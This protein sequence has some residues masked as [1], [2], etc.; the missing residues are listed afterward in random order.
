MLS[1]QPTFTAY[2]S[3][4]KMESVGVISG[5]S[6][7][8]IFKKSYRDDPVA[9]IHD[10]IKWREGE[11][12]T[13]Y[14]DEIMS[15][16]VSE[17]RVSVRA[18][19]G[20]GKTAVVAWAV[21]WFALTNDGDI[22][23]KIP[24]T[25]SAW[26]QLSHFAMPEVH[27]WS[28]ALVWD[29]IGRAPYDTRIELT[30]LTLSLKTGEMFALASDNPA[31]LEGAHASRLLYIFDE[32][33]EIPVG[34][35]DSAEGAFSA[36]DCKWLSV[37][38]PGEP[39]GRFYDIQSRTPGTEDWFVRHITLEEAIGSGRISQKWANDRLLQWGE[40]SAVYQNRVLGEFASSEESGVIPLSWVEKAV[41]RW[42][43][44]RDAGSVLPEFTCVGADIARSGEDR[45]VLAL[46]FENI[47]TELRK[48]SREDTMETTGRI[49]GIL[50]KY[51]GY[52]AVDV[53]GIGAGVVDRLRELKYNV[54][55]FNASEHTDMLDATGELMFANVRSAAWWNMRELLDPVNGHEIA[56][57]P[58]DLL[59]G[60]LTSVHW[61]VQSGGKIIIEPKD[62]I[63][64]R[65]GR[66]TDDG[67]A[68][69]QAF[70]QNR[71]PSATDWTAAVKR[72]QAEEV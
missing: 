60:D 54:F 7:Y 45:T 8:E 55:A 12:P 58:D 9:F 53:I 48:H 38:T 30:K 41:E 39:N 44:W 35:W 68:V 19:H 11:Q 50:Q 43:A 13:A 36:G 18:P 10:C 24:V 29:K 17:P 57:P 71:Q 66:S 23:W 27:K 3:R 70:F 1:Y 42:E 64:E 21:H 62:D 25:A 61:Q 72:R 26:R 15:R 56:L 67:D 47:L 6:P 16:L 28:R 5:G 40:Q 32:S 63:K 65:I 59:I 46:R 33:K 14:Q 4:K 20:V 51:G 31:L 69:V 49:V 2:K 34:T 37:S 52:A 22:D